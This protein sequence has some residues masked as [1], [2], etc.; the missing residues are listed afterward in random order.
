MDKKA[1]NAQVFQE[2]LN[3]LADLKAG[4]Y[5][6][7]EPSKEEG[8]REIIQELNE[9]SS[10]LESRAA[11]NASEHILLEE[12]IN[13]TPDWIFIKD[14]EHR[15]LKVN[16]GYAQAL[17]LKPSDFIGKTDIDLGFPE[18]LVKGNPKKG[19]TGFW[20]LDNQVVKSGKTLVLENDPAMIDGKLHNFHTIKTPVRNY[21]NEIY[22][23][24]GFARD[25]TDLVQ[26]QKNLDT[27]R[28]KSVTNAK[29]ASLG[30]MSAGLAHEINNP[31]AIIE[32]SLSLLPRFL[33]NTE[34]LN[35]RIE[36]MKR[37]CDRIAKIVYG[38]KKFSR[39]GDRS[40][41]SPYVLS[42]IVRDA[43]TL[44]EIKSKRD[45]TPV[46][47]ELNSDAT[48]LCN[49]VEIEQVLVNLI[50][51]AIDA[52]KNSS[53]RWV[54]V[55]VTDSHDS[56]ILSVMDSGQGIPEEVRAKLFEPFFTT[57]NVGEGTGLGLSI[58][59]GI[60]DEH[61]AS[62]SLLNDSPNTCFEVRFPKN[63]A[64]KDAA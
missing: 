39:S 52:V 26:L 36:T 40:E 13:S 6:K 20:P 51:N 41:V 2:I 12:I 53:D 15:Y 57:K 49:E 38:L 33:N 25:I 21:K 46:I 4:K 59:K 50:S 60:L 14:L 11:E 64:V 45:S 9:V 16:A 27:E 5:R 18:E 58:T 37:S 56:T 19:I 48:V 63:K 43:L 55:L 28:M 3:V 61:G 47:C 23:V 7:I 10:T 54:K 44:T 35:A 31:L 29:L 8:F 24:L 30:E 17:H 42:S 34:K 22:G 32:G 1:K 62:I